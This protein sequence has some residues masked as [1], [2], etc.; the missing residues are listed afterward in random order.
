MQKKDLTFDYDSI[1]SYFEN[2]MLVF[3]DEIGLSNSRNSILRKAKKSGVGYL[4]ISDDDL[5]HQEDGVFQLF[6][7]MR[8]NGAGVCTAQ[9]KKLP[10]YLPQKKYINKEVCA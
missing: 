10:Q 8:S 3:S 4:L 7:H 9:Y 5:L 1:A 6:Q 2:L